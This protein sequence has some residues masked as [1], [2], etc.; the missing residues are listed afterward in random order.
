MDYDVEIVRTRPRHVAVIR[1]EA[2]AET[3][4]NLVGPA[5]G[6]VAADLE[7][8][9]IPAS[10][11]AVA[12]Y[13]MEPEGFAVAAGLVVDDPVPGDGIVEPMDLP[14]VEVATTLHVGPYEKLV[15]A[16]AAIERTVGSVGR[17]LDEHHMW[18]EYLDGPEVPLERHRTVISWPLLPV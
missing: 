16:Y 13:D 12:H 5:F 4:S 1:F 14:A 15:E 9:H 18:E 8:R 11:P 3:M 17:R 6:A 10:G 2:T 7:Q